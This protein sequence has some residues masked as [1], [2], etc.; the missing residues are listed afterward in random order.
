MAALQ[1]QVISINYGK[2]LDKKTDPK[3]VQ[4]GKMLRLENA[5]FTAANRINKRNGNT[6]LT[7]AISGGGTISAPKAAQAF[8]DELVCAATASGATYNGKRMLSFSQTLNAW[9]DKGKYAPNK[10]T[11]NVVSADFP[12]FGNSGAA[13]GNYIATTWMVNTT[14]TVFN[15]Y[16]TI[17]DTADNVA[18]LPETLLATTAGSGKLTPIVSVVGTSEFGVFYT[19][20]SNALV[21]R[22]ITISGSTVTIGAELTIQTSSTGF[23]DVC[24]TPT[25]AAISAI[26]G[27]VHWK[28]Y[29]IDTAGTVTH[30]SATIATTSTSS[31]TSINFDGTN[32]WVFSSFTGL[33]K[34]TVLSSTLAVVLAVTS[35]SAED[36]NSA[37]SIWGISTSSTAQLFFYTNLGVICSRTI[38]SAGVVGSEVQRLSNMAVFGASIVVGGA[39]YLVVTNNYFSNYTQSTIYLMDIA[40]NMLVAKCLS[41]KTGFNLTTI[42]PFLESGSKIGMVAPYMVQSTPVQI[43][44]TMLVEFDFADADLYQASLAYPNM[45]WNGGIV[46]QYDGQ[47][48]VELGFNQYP[49][50]KQLVAHTTGGSMADGDYEYA[51]VYEWYDLNGALHQSAPSIGK[52]TTIT[53]GGGSGSVTLTYTNLGATSKVSP[54][55]PVQIVIYRTDASGTLLHRVNVS[56]SSYIPNNSST[57]QYSDF[58]DVAADATIDN[59]PFL[60]TT[61]GVLENIAPPP[62]V[63][64]KIHNNRYQLIDS[65]NDNTVWYCKSIQPGVG[66]SFTDLLTVQVGAVGGTLKG[67]A[68]MDDK[69]VM[70]AQKQPIVMSGDGANDLGQGSTLS[71]PQPVPS[72]VGGQGSKSVF[73]SP[74]GVHFKTSKGL[75]LLDRSLAVSY[76]GSDIEAYNS[77]DITSALIM[78][79]TTQMRFLTSSGLTLC[80]DYFYGQWST[81]TNFEGFGA[82]VWQGAYTYARSDGNVYTENFTSF[83]DDTTAFAVKA[84]TAW[85]KGSA[86]QGFQRLK[87][88]LQLGD[89]ANGSDATHGT[90]ISF[91]YDYLANPDL[92]SF[93]DPTVFTFGDASTSGPFQYREFLEQ[94]KCEAVSFLIEEVVTGASG[95]SMNL[96]DLTIVAGVKRGAFKM[97]AAQTAS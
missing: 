72:D 23:F 84:Q 82:D 63:A 44:G 21:V 92:P 66:V 43:Q 93:T 51:V 97:A 45:L 9:V 81:F 38:T 65:E 55:F 28:A 80:Y 39:T 52:S 26:D 68:S 24:N 88:L 42:R 14:G 29:T 76:W 7:N 50:I 67:L 87:Q 2:G 46:Q 79:G 59:N 22:I 4:I 91:A 35:I 27:S 64:L 48:M 94:Q 10:V 19:N 36:G 83:L 16:M 78:P 34:Y 12:G 18:I 13:F 95:E 47:A 89:Y 3:T 40:D 86:V 57:S 56:T 69:L 33:A 17:Q 20:S 8:G 30:T 90:Q 54:R 61:G 74:L 41:S 62:T 70:L 85:L 37:W 73:T 71:F 49:E 75:F 53:G 32:F 5:V 60:Y 96:G 11:N 6:K 31:R 1:D 15:V 25:G 58:I 77:Q